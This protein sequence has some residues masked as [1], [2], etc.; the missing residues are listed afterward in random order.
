MFKAKQTVLALVVGLFCFQTTFVWAQSATESESS[1]SSI[2]S[3]ATQMAS[4]VTSTVVDGTGNLINNAMNLI[5]VRYRWGGNSPQTG[6]DCS[7]FVRYVFNDTFGLSVITGLAVW[8][9]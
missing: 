2:T 6:L 3:A 1:A 8:M 9:V 7:G 4:S 5:G